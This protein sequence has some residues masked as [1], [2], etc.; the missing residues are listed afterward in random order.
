MPLTLSLE[1]SADVCAAALVADGEALGVRQVEMSRG[2]AEAL[3]PMVQD[4]AQQVGVVLTA[5]DLI[6]VTRGPGSFTGVRTG[7]AAARGFAIAS[8]APAVGVSSLEAVARGA[9]RAADMASSPPRP[10]PRPILCILDTRRADYFAQ[11]FDQAGAASSAPAVMSPADLFLLIG[12]LQ[13]VLAGN[14][15]SRFLSE[16]DGDPDTLQRAPG[17]GNPDPVDVALIAE[18]ILGNEGVAKDTLSPLYLRAP[19]AKIPANGGRLKR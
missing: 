7:I 17:T 13:P 16:Y 12:S 11:T 14:A 1:T 15:V 4:L 5:L 8:G 10:I 6:G 2:H 19:E 3:V 18:T 9:A